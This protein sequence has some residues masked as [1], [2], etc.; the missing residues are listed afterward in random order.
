MSNFFWVDV[1][2]FFWDDVQ[3]FFCVHCILEHLKKDD[4]LTLEELTQKLRD[5][6]INVSK[7]TV[8]RK[9]RQIGYESKVAMEGHE[10]LLQQKEVRL[11]C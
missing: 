10:L 2:L 11:K 9:L 7:E 5:E 8:R 4:S 6:G 3:Q 1:Q